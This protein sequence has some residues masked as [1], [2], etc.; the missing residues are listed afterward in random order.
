MRSLTPA[1]STAITGSLGSVQLIEMDLVA[2]F[3]RLA[4]AGVD[5]DWS[6]NTFLGGKAA[7][8]EAIT[9]QGGEIAGLRFTLSGV[10]PDMLALALGEQIQGRPVTV[11]HALLDT[12]SQAIIDVQQAW[13]GTLDQM[14]ITDGA[15]ATISVTAE[16][17]GIAF[18][19]QKGLRYT[20]GDQQAIAPGD[21]CLEFIIAQS[22]HQDVWPAASFFRH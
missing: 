8:V 14:H 9:D 13:A 15:S 17:P 5:I 19:R 6:V 12:A 10:P 20:D 16:H 18:A 21:K 2:G 11:Y 4:M 22:S 3:I 7:A 1:G